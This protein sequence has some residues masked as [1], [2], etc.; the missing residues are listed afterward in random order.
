MAVHPEQFTVTSYDRDVQNN[1]AF[2]MVRGQLLILVR[3]I[4]N[5]AVNY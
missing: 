5:G 4:S 3:K 2:A 1:P